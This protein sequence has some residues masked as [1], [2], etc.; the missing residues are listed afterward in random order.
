MSY[1]FDWDRANID[2]VGRH[3]VDPQ[4]VEEVFMVRPLLR[5]VR[6]GRLAALGQTLAGRYMIIFFERVNRNM[7]RVITARTMGETE[8]RWYRRHRGR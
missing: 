1:V 2:H 8:R 3:G 7:V 6:G 5:R 4:E